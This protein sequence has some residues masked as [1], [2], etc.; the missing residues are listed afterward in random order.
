VGVSKDAARGDPTPYPS[1]F[2]GG[3]E[4]PS[5]PHPEF[6]EGRDSPSGFSPVARFHCVRFAK[7]FARNGTSG[8]LP[9]RVR[10]PEGLLKPALSV[11]R[12]C[13]GS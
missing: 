1:P 7:R 4:A 10:K 6:I 5:P 3:E 9:L 8:Y 11:V 12:L 13:G 2:R